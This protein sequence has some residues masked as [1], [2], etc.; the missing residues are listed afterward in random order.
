MWCFLP[1]FPIDQTMTAFADI[2]ALQAKLIEL[3]EKLTH[4]HEQDDLEKMLSC[5]K[6]CVSLT[7]TVWELKQKRCFWGLDLK[8]QILAIRYFHSVLAGV[9][10][11]CWQNYY[12]KMPI[13]ISL[14][15]QPTTWDIFAKDWFLD[16]LKDAPFGFMLVCHERYFLD[17]LCN[18]ILE[19]EQGKATFY[20]GNY[21]AYEIQKEHNRALLESAYQLQQKE[22][23]HKQ[24]IINKFRASASRAKQ[25][26]SMIKQLDKLERI[27]LPPTLKTMNFSFLITRSGTL[28]LKVDNVAF[29]FGD[30]ESLKM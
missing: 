20:Q 8:K 1:R 28:V 21:S 6:S 16:F 11:L 17:A 2:A 29:S 15:S 25:A 27:G 10:E 14:M 22:I 9:C 24:E 3:E 19:L 5:M 7:P 12:C 4:T 30:R 13:F 18:Q 23:K 26:Q